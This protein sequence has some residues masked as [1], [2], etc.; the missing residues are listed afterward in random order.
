MEGKIYAENESLIQ[1]IHRI[2]NELIAKDINNQHKKRP[3]LSLIAEG[4][5]G[6]A[7]GYL[8]AYEGVLDRLAK[9]L[10]SALYIS[11]L[12][13]KS[14]IAEGRLI[15]SFLKLVEEEY[16]SKGKLIPIVAE[17]REGTSYELI[18]SHLEEMGAKYGVRYEL[19]EVDKYRQGHDTMR[20]VIL[21]PHALQ[22]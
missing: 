11:D 21:R 8:I 1:Y 5:A 18:Q 17:A 13:S 3:N 7:Q 2:G 16:L 12:A 10:T 4:D 14:K 19:E 20:T 15:S 6:S 22:K 9:Q